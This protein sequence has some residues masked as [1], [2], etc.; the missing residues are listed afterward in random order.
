[1][2][3][4]RNLCENNSANQR[5]IADLES[6]G[7]VDNAQLLEELGCQVEIG[8]DGKMKVKGTTKPQ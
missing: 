7:V 2:V 5:L 1:M 6:K 3:A 8:K 4:I